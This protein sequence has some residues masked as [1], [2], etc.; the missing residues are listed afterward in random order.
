MLFVDHRALF[1]RLGDARFVPICSLIST[2]V[3]GILSVLLSAFS[4]W[5]LVCVVFGLQMASCF[6]PAHE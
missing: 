2:I 3:R 4:S 6:S 1:A 5:L